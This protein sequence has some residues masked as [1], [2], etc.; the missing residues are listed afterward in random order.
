MITPFTLL[1]IFTSLLPANIP[2]NLIYM[3]PHVEPIH[4]IKVRRGYVVDGTSMLLTPSNFIRLKSVVENSP[5]LC[6]LAVDE[7]IKKCLEGLEREQKIMLNREHDD[8]VLIKAYESRLLSIE[9]DLDRSQKKQRVLLYTAVSLAL[10]ATASITL[11]V[12]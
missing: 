5:D 9:A 8:Q 11:A 7:S 3:G 12:R 10:V 1:F 6:T 2:P 4:S